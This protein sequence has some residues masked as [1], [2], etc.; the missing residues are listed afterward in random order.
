MGM[1]QNAGND[2]KPLF[3]QWSKENPNCTDVVENIRLSASGDWIMIECSECVALLSYMSRVGQEFWG[4]VTKF[5]GKSLGLEVIPAKGKLGFDV[6]PSAVK[7]VWE[8]VEDDK[9]EFSDG[10][11]SIHRTGFTSDLWD[12]MV[13]EAER[14]I[15]E[16]KENK[17]RA[18]SNPS[19]GRKKRPAAEVT[20][21]EAIAP[22]SGL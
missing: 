15:Q 21:P 11:Q 7:G 12:K 13:R 2:R 8:W 16:D 18:G 4:E 19:N 3:R 20:T 14:I 10:S 9:V 6:Q 22:E 5:K 17:E 1:L